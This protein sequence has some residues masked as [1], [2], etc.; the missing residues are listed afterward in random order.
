MHGKLLSAAYVT[1]GGARQANIA[2]SPP[3]YLGIDFDLYHSGYK[4]II[5]FNFYSLEYIC[6]HILKPYSHATP[7]MYSCN[8]N[9]INLLHIIASDSPAL[10]F[11]ACDEITEEHAMADSEV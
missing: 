5:S 10:I 8:I 1:G 4:S 9:E 3:S 2:P 11:R 6:A 7:P